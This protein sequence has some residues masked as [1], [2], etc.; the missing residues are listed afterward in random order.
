MTKN[1]IEKRKSNKAKP[2]AK[3]EQK[4]KPEPQK[5]DNTNNDKLVVLLNNL[6][7]LIICIILCFIIPILLLH[8]LF[9]SLFIK[10]E[11]TII[12][13][14]PGIY[15]YVSCCDTIEI[16]ENILKLIK[17]SYNKV[18]TQIASSIDNLLKMYFIT[19]LFD[20]KITKE[21]LEAIIKNVGIIGQNIPDDKKTELQKQFSK[22]ECPVKT[23]TKDDIDILLSNIPGVHLDN[24]EQFANITS[25]EISQPYGFNDVINDYKNPRKYLKPGDNNYITPSQVRTDLGRNVVSKFTTDD[26]YA[27]L[28]NSRDNNDTDYKNYGDKH[29]Q[30]IRI[31][32][33]KKQD[34]KPKNKS[35]RVFIRFST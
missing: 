28:L 35:R 6:L 2:K 27:K 34:Y 15:D 20:I 18:I 33:S 29:I 12:S 17:S 24:L 1:S 9:V 25:G 5:D 7:S 32:G 8:M 4:P 16:P 31:G 19:R 26:K 23:L 30:R 22:N 13:E 11:L 10:P 14:I 3:E 21:N